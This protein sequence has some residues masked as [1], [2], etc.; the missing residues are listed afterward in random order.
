MRETIVSFSLHV[1]MPYPFEILSV[2]QFDLVGSILSRDFERYLSTVDPYFTRFRSVSKWVAA[3]KNDLIDN[4]PLFS[5]DDEA[6]KMVYRQAM[7]DMFRGHYQCLRI[8]ERL[9]RRVVGE[10][11]RGRILAEQVAPRKRVPTPV[12]GEKNTFE[13]QGYKFKISKRLQ[14]CWVM[15]WD[16]YVACGGNIIGAHEFNDRKEMLVTAMIARDPE[17]VANRRDLRNYVVARPQQ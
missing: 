16:H 5:T 1:D 14:S 15:P 6:Q 3:R 2:D 13:S 17:W 12:Q 7:D 8:R 4:H 9:H 11:S 10:R